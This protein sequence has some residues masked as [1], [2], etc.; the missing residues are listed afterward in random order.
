MSD[1][2]PP[3]SSE[4]PIKEVLRA[5][6]D[7]DM[8]IEGGW[9]YGFEDAMRLLSLP[10][11]TLTQL[12]YT[13]ASMRTHIEMHMTLSA[14]ERYSGI[15]L[16]ETARRL[17]KRDDKIYEIVTYN[18]TAM[19][20]KAYFRFIQDYKEGYGKEG[21]DIDAHFQARKD[22]TLHRTILLHFDITALQ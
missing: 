5:A 4:D 19:K 11:G 9:G 20:E 10:S 15:S 17:E 1:T 13:L 6:F 8:E 3:L 2:I 21:F 14:D 12:Q 22:A 16:N 7:F 18:V